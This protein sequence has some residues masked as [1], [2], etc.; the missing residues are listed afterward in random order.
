MSSKNMRVSASLRIVSKAFTAKEIG[1]V[2]GT[3]T[4]KAF[5]VGERMSRRNPKSAVRDAAIWILD[6]HAPDNTPIEAHLGHL[7]DFVD[8]HLGQL[9]ELAEKSSF[10]Y[11][12]ALS[13]VDNDGQGGIALPSS[14]LA[15][16]L[17]IPASIVLDVYYPSGREDEGRDGGDTS[18]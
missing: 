13:F 16:L 18:I 1:A 14:L 12:C 4:A 15:R 8:A 7:A 2:L 6:A 9:L 5:E 3:T 17:R 10:D 11:W